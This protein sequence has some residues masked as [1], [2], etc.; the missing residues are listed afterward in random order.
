MTRVVP[1]SLPGDARD[2][3]SAMVDAHYDR[4]YRLARRLAGSA[5]EARDLV[6]DTFLKAAR[7]PAAVPHGLTAEERWLVR[8]LVNVRRDQWRK[9]AVRRRHA[10]DVAA[11]SARDSSR[12]HNARPSSSDNLCASLPASFAAIT[13]RVA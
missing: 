8:V 12:S 13:K 9:S 11:A 1:V 7:A 3:L 4:L 5:D 2:R 6:Q 10:P